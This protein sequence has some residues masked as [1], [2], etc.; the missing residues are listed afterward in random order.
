[1]RHGADRESIDELDKIIENCRFRETDSYM[2]SIIDPVLE[3]LMV[4]ECSAKDADLELQ[5]KVELYFSE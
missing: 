5:S 4:G 3:K 1:L 2:D